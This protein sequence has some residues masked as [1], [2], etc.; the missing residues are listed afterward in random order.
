MYRHAGGSCTIDCVQI[1][2]LLFQPND[3]CPTLPATADSAA[4]FEHAPPLPEP[5]A[6]DHDNHAGQ[7]DPPDDGCTLPPPV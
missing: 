7:K 2:Q 1:T 5:P 3:Q 6:P 4:V